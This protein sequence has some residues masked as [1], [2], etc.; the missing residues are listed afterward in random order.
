MFSIGSFSRL[1]QLSIRVLRHYDQIDLLVPARVNPVNGYRFYTA[2]QLADAHRIV[3]LKEL[4]LG[5]DDIK[6]LV[7]EDHSVDTIVGMLRLEQMRTEASR[8][9]A[10]RRLRDLNRRFNELTDLGRLSDVELV[11]KSVPA[12]PYFAHRGLSENIGAAYARMERIVACCAPFCGDAP[13]LAVAHDTFFDTVHL[14]LEIGY[15]VAE[16]SGFAPS[17]SLP[18]AERVLPAVERMLC[19]VYVGS[20]EE[21]HRRSHHAMALWLDSHRCELGGPGRE[22]IYGPM[23]SDSPH[24]VEIQYP[25]RAQVPLP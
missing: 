24:T 12:S 9:Q 11:E 16:P 10:E 21:S 3:A 23:D 4:G 20:E 6:T 13:L 18:M 17:P 25:V 1:T 8:R 7:K 15:P 22:L 5:L 2:S 14:D 19:A